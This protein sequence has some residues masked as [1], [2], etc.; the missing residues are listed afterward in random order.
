MKTYEFQFNNDVES[1]LA[2]A[3]MLRDNW[4]VASSHMDSGFH[5]FTLKNDYL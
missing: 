3:S 5:F 2:L 1:C 4:Y